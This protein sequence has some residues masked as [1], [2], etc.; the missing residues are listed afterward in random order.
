MPRPARINSPRAAVDQTL[1]RLAAREPR[2]SRP[3]AAKGTPSGNVVATFIMLSAM[4]PMIAPLSETYA[5][6]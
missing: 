1:S 4:R 5:D 2:C 6:F 3:F